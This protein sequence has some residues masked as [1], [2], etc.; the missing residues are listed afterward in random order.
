MGDEFD[1]L[2]LEAERRTERLIALLRV[3]IAVSLGVVL[4]FAVI[5]DAPD[6]SI[7]RSTA[8]LVAWATLAVYAVIGIV[9]RLLSRRGRFRRYYALVFAVLDVVFVVFS[10]HLSAVNWGLTSAYLAALPT[11]WIVPIVIAFGAMRYSVWLQVLTGFLLLLGIAWA[12]AP[13]VTGSIFVIDAVPPGSLA[14]MFG[15][16]GNSLRLAMLL[17]ACTVITVA[18]ART[19]RL[20]HLAI[21]Q[22]QRRR[23]LTKFM[24]PKVAEII[25]SRGAAELRAGRRQ[26]VGVLFVDIRGFTAR[27]ER[28][29]PEAVSAFLTHYRA[30]LRKAADQSGG[31]IDKFVGDGAMIV[32]GVP[33]P[34]E[35]EAA[36]AL[37]CG[38]DICR[39][40][41]A[42]SDALVASGE[43]P[44]R[45]GIGIH[46]GEAFVGA[47]GDEER[48][49]FTVIGDTVNVAARIEDL[50]RTL[51][52]DIVATAPVLAEAGEAGGAWRE[53]T[54]V[55]IRGRSEPVTIYATG[56]APCSI[57]EGE[58]RA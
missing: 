40:I 58:A 17:L 39:R 37:E 19:R 14:G 9:A 32:F 18:S 4:Y 3:L 46:C 57:A 10:L 43:E 23:S 21:E 48:L 51:K 44:V 7:L 15:E 8:I 28:M 25:E 13:T 52:A 42:W 45:V 54:E 56:C 1:D 29:P 53:L 50:S 24:P 30:E 27:T 35:S 22:G 55:A 36:L 33:K 5:D 11:A 41:A 2:I 31:V 20:V 6:W 26:Q 12:S 34:H 38:R 49:E 16:I 47:V